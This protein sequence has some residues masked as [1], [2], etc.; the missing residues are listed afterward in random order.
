MTRSG[1][2]LKESNL[3]SLPL[4]YFQILGQIKEILSKRDKIKIILVTFFQI[5][6]SILDL[7]SVAV[8]GLLTALTV[9]GIQSKQPGGLVWKT[10]NA[11]GME[12]FSFQ[13]QAAILG[14]AS[15]SL[16]LLR[17]ILSLWFSRRLLLFLNYRGAAFSSE[18]IR[19]LLSQP[20]L[21]VQ[22]NSV[23]QTIFLVTNGVGAI[24]NGIIAVSVSLVAD[25]ALILVMLAGL[26]LVSPITSVSMTLA[27][28]L[29]GFTLYQF[30]KHRASR[31]A[32]NDA[33]WSVKSNQKLEEVLV[34]YR[35][36]TVR[37]RRDYYSS[38]ISNY[39]FKMA[40][41]QAE[42]MFIP[43]ISKYVVEM[44]LVFGSLILAAIQFMQNDAIHAISVL[45]IF[46]ASGSRIAPAILRMQQGALQIRSS[47]SVASNTMALWTQI[48]MSPSADMREVLEFDN[49]PRAEFLPSV[50]LNQISFTYPG[51]ESETLE[52][53]SLTVNPGEM[54]AIVGSSGAGKTTL[55]DLILGVIAPTKGT[56]LISDIKPEVAVRKFVGA[57]SYV[58]QDILIVDGTIRE[59][60]ALGYP[61]NQIS[62]SDIWRALRAAQL[63]E[64]VRNL[65]MQIDHQ[66]GERGVNLSGGQR[67]RLGLARGLY[68]NPKLLVL[69]EATSAL[70]GNTEAGITEMLYSLRGKIT[71]LVIAHR[72]STIKDAERIIYLDK[73]K[74]IAEG[75]FLE[76]SRKVPGFSPE[77]ILGTA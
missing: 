71:L 53:I 62:N 28:S 52:N 23:Q 38:I 47:I 30:L 57:I 21:V 12:N 37:N 22:K 13:Q 17:T 15:G 76:V 3:G 1:R 54:L 69:D 66:I 18:L 39:R 34:S 36:A 40:K 60:V 32:I 35:E 56:A 24:T 25:L 2:L 49:S 46:L 27:L 45:S 4:H 67:Q 16:L 19:Q 59:N 7:A 11:T 58:P 6:L 14:I 42:A 48:K 68:S 55:V 29:V 20:L 33:S 10:I 75:N 44:S 51:M 65:P 5:G 9:N 72:L 74:I 43:S 50:N 70:D 8:I 61:E 64:F 26:T 77:K 63:E 41:A 31:L 73:G